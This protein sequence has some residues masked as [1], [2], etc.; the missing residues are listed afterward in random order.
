M[1]GF[2][3]GVLCDFEQVGH[4]EIRLRG[5]GWADEE[6][7]VHQLRMLGELIC[8]GVNSHSLDT[9][10][11]GRPADSTGDFASVCFQKFSEHFF[12]CLL[13]FVFKL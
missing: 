3:L 12:R 4:L 8:L 11:M 5:G 13:V 7:L 10:S 6:G 2:T 9:E 1:N